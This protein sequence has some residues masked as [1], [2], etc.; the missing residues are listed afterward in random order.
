VVDEI[1]RQGRNWEIYSYQR[2]C[3]REFI[4]GAHLLPVRPA[5][6]PSSSIPNALQDDEIAI[7]L[8][9]AIKTASSSSVS[10]LSPS[11]RSNLE[12]ASP[13]MATTTTTTTT[14]SIRFTTQRR[15][16]VAGN[17]GRT[18][19]RKSTPASPFSAELTNGLLAF[20][21]EGLVGVRSWRQYNLRNR[22]LRGR[23]LGK[24]LN[25]LAKANSRAA[26]PCFSYYPRFSRLYVSPLRSRVSTSS[27]PL[28]FRLR[29]VSR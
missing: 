10:P 3:S 17:G 13:S 20:A 14:T 25:G 4:T 16:L 22:E 15:G 28:L 23:G 2:L 19:S 18:G 24:R 5:P 26:S 8:E 27:S 6:L 21:E 29:L 11:C 1:S 7:F 9:D 12:S